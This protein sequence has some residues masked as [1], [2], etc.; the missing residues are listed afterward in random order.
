MQDVWTPNRVSFTQKYGVI[1]KE[2]Q[3]YK[4]LSFINCKTFQNDSS[5]KMRQ[6]NVSFGY[7]QLMVG[8]ERH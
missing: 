8:S 4:N 3:D 7:A 1:D 2:C 6:K 5:F